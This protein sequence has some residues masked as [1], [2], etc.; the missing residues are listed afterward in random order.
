MNDA[1]GFQ[2]IG[3]FEAAADFDAAR[4][5]QI[6]DFNDQCVGSFEARAADGEFAFVL[7]FAAVAF[8]AFDMPC[9]HRV[10]G[11]LRCGHIER[12]AEADADGSLAEVQAYRVH[13]RLAGGAHAVETA[14]LCA[15]PGP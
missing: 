9:P 14:G 13:R 6:R 7:M 11:G 2:A 12:V 5:L 1:L 3:E 15:V 8:R 10:A 4:R